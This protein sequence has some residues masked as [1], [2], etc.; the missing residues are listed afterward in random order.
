MAITMVLVVVNAA[1]AGVGIVFHQ[2]KL[3]R[4]NAGLKPLHASIKRL[5]R[6]PCCQSK[7]SKKN[8]G[9]KNNGKSAAR[10]K[11]KENIRKELYNVG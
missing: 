1:K 4:K 11:S 2:S 8:S 6:C 5:S 3:Q 7:Y 9:K 10:F